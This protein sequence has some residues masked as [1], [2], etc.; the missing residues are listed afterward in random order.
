MVKKVMI[1][2]KLHPDGMAVLVPRADI[3]TLYLDGDK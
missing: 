3:E 2:E 1:S